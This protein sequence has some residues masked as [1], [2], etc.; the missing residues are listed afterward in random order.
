MEVWGEGDLEGGGL[1]G[2]GLVGGGR[3]G[4]GPEGRRLGGGE[5][6]RAKDGGR[7]SRTEVAEVRETRRDMGLDR[8]TAVAEAPATDH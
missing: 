8:P 3:G 7:E 5:T 2:G 6:W 1:E 4:G